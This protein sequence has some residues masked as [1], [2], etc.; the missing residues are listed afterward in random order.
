MVE[1]RH[2]QLSYQVRGLIFEARKNLKTGWAEEIYHQGL[3]QL[4]RENRVP[5]ESKPR[6][7]LIH[8][9]IAIHSFECDLIVAERIILELKALPE[10]AFA[11]AHYAQL[12]N[13]LKCWNKDLGLLV[14]FGSSTAQ[15]ERVVWDEPEWAIQ[16][17]YASIKTDLTGADRVCLRQIR[18]NI[19][20]IGKQYGFGYFDTVYRKLVAVEM[21][22]SGLECRA[23]VEIPVKWGDTIL[24]R[25]GSEHLL[26]A[27]CF[28][29]NIQ[30]L[31]ARPSRYD[32]AQMKTFLNHL[33]L[34]FGIIVNFGKKQ[35]QIHTVNRE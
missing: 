9:G 22:H 35:L 26:V 14:N 4:L 23:E 8:R 3:A 18:Q 17:D 13:Y 34:K 6:K 21:A 29:I 32:F 12:I 2:E 11:P 31:R 7:T 1:L 15:I 24:T 28:L 20:T 25:Q 30:S 19:F 16:E 10:N 33:N 27:K 5:F